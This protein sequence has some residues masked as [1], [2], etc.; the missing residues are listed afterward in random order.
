MEWRLVSSSSSR[1]CFSLSVL[2]KFR[3][4]ALPVS[5]VLGDPLLQRG[6]W[7]QW[8]VVDQRVAAD[9]LLVPLLL[10]HCRLGLRLPT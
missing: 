6:Q 4:E 7:A 5:W 10:V 2:P 9:I 8:L 3:R 1:L